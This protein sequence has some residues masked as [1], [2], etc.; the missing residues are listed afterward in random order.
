VTVNP[1][2]DLA[3]GANY[4]VQ[5]DST[6]LHDAAGNNYAGISTSTGL[7]FTTASASVGDPSI[8]VFDLTTGQ[9]S[10]HNGRVFDANT[11]YTIYIKVNSTYSPLV[12]LI[13]TKCGR[14]RRIWARTTRLCWWARGVMLRKPWRRS[15]R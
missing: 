3:A 11:A 7:N 2:T 9:S 10:E 12:G 5:I 1:T 4:H 15:K 8:V 13:A 6:A 14:A